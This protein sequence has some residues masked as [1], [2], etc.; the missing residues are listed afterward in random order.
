MIGAMAA[1]ALTVSLLTTT[2]RADDDFYDDYDDSH[3]LR[4]VARAVNPVGYTLEWLVLRPIHALTSQPQLR[5]VFGTDPYG[6]GFRNFDQPGDMTTGQP[7]PPPQPTLSES[8]LDALRRAA[9]EAQAAADEAKRAADEAK[10]AAE[11]ATRAADKSG[12]AFEK[13]LMK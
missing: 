12:K 9:V 3:P 10:L 1:V 8:D 11:E 6:P 4:L 5:P 2:V 13:S 7:T